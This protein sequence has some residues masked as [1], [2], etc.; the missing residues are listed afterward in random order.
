MADL[1]DEPLWGRKAYWQAWALL[2]VYTASMDMAGNA[3]PGAWAWRQVLALNLLQALVWG[4]A[5]RGVIATANRFPVDEPRLREWKRLSVQVLAVV[6]ATVFAL[7]ATWAVSLPF[8]SGTDRAVILADPVRSFSRFFWMY[9]HLNLLLMVA[10]LGLNHG[11]RLQ[12]RFRDK[13]L[14]AAHLVSRLSEAQNRALRMQIQPHFLFNTLHSIT[15]LIHEDPEAAERMLNRLA[16]L[17]RMTLD[18]GNRQEIT[19]R[20]ELSYIEHY[21]AIE[22]IRFEDRLRVRYDVAPDCQEARVPAFLLQ[23]LVENAVKHG[24]SDLSRESTIAIHAQKVA[25]SLDLV[26]EDDGLG[27]D[28]E[29]CPGT[30]TRLT[31]E[32]LELLYRGRYLFTI[33]GEPGKGTSAHIRI[34]W[35]TATH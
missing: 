19:L 3:L 17:L 6:V 2:G 32:R 26:V 5:G 35:V 21:L 4:L 24:F 16:D 12:E 14:E 25:Q 11:W 8:L 13:Q 7:I 10:V 9:V 23:P 15:A 31:S 29:S 18:L 33:N 22:A 27:Y 28:G 34:P 20:Q 30:G 1:P